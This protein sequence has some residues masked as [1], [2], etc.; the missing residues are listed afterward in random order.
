MTMSFKPLAEWN[1]PG[2]VYWW[3]ENPTLTNYN[4]TI[5]GGGDTGEARAE[6]SVSDLPA[7]AV[8]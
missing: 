5:L 1:P 4:R 8:R 6:I 3:P 2:Q 7:V